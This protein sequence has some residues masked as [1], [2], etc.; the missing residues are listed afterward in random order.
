VVGA[1]LWVARCTRPDIAFA[2]H[3][4]TRRTHQ[5]TEGDWKL[6]KKILRY[7]AG[8]M[9]VKLTMR[10]ESMALANGGGR[11]ILVEGFSDADFAADANDRKSVSGN[12][13]MVAGSIVAWTCRKQ[14][15]VALSTMEAE[16]TSASSAAQ[17]LLGL[18]NLLTELGVAH[19]LPMRLGVDNQAAISQI[20]SEASSARAK[21]IDIKVKAIKHQ[22]RAGLIRA[23][24][25]ASGDMVAD[26]LTKALPAPRLSQLRTLIGLEEP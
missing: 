5:P 18:S 4:A 10:G 2:V 15:S 9:E 1:L 8:T 24:Y 14:G 3:R 7:L 26:L 20:T 13:T 25:V 11:T 16:F 17:E 19:E 22:A 12:V 21:H 23:E 6:A